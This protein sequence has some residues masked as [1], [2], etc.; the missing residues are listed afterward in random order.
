LLKQIP[1]IP[2][3]HII[4]QPL[5]FPGPPKFTQIGIF[6]IKI[7]HLATLLEN[8]RFEAEIYFLLFSQN[9]FFFFFFSGISAF[10]KGK[11]WT[12]QF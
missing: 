5:P 1:N 12:D 11:F 8:D 3:G 10:V 9:F 7:Y 2:C 4:F 6:G